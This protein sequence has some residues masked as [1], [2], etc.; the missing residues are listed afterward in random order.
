MQN[1]LDIHIFRD[2]IPNAQFQLSLVG[3]LLEIC[4]TLFG[5]L[6]QIIAIRFGTKT[7]LVLGT[8][9]VTLG[10]ELA[11][12]ATKIWHLH[13][14]QGVM[15][16]CGA[17]LLFVA[18]MAITPLWFNK[19]RGLATGIASGGIGIGGGFLPFVITAINDTLG[20]AWTFRI[21]GLIY[22]VCDVVACVFIKNKVP[23]KPKKELFSFKR[24]FDMSTF[25]NV[26][27]L[28]WT[29]GSVISTMGYFVPFFFL[30]AYATY[31]GLSVAQ[32]SALIAVMS[33]F[34]FM[35]RMMVGYIG[36]SI[37]R[38]NSHI[39]FTFGAAL[40]NFF[41]WTFAQNYAILMVYSTLFGLFCASYYSM[42]KFCFTPEESEY[43]TGVSTLL[44][45]NT[46]SISGII[47]AGAIELST[48]H[49][50]P[51]LQ[52]FQVLISTPEQYK[53]FTGAVY[54]AGGPIL[55]A[56][57]IRIKGLFARF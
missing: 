34:S 23:I 1:Y 40:S 22:L 57:R 55:L 9:F 2:R 26:S 35:G 31:L 38:L 50:E 20:I 27:F 52:P 10:V 15:F 28:L 47:I 53:M 56:L 42:N 49:T 21:L 41:V 13:L 48:T 12:F 16:G 30:P 46:I 25:R 45:S 7:V 4:T 43:R 14:T 39:I 36:D 18:R 24:V 17:S 29:C 54:F 33:A 8:L 32:S 5:P 37:G 44:L 11:S 19:R 3:T 51:Y 6:A